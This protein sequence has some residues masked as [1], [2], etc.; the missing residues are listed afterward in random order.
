MKLFVDTSPFIY[1]VESHAFYGEKVQDLFLNSI[2]RNDE[3][4]TSVITLMEFSVMTQK[5]KRLDLIEKYQDL[6]NRLGIPLIEITQSMAEHAALMRSKY[7]FLK[8][9]DALQLAVA[10]DSGCIQFITNDKGL[11]RITEIQV[12]TLDQF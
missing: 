3:L 11:Q 12:M 4:I 1:L 8:P 5:T 2:A 10:I 7:E 9:M 6:L